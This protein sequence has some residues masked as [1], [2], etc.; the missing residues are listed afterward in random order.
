MSGTTAPGPLSDAFP[1][2]RSWLSD[3]APIETVPPTRADL[4]AAMFGLDDFARNTVLLAAFCA[5]EPEGAQL[6]A[7]LQGGGGRGAATVAL[8]L[9]RVPGAHWSAFAAQAP[10]RAWALIPAASGDSLTSGPLDLPES[11]LFY[12]LGAA[13]LSEELAL[14]SRRLEPPADLSPARRRLAD[15]IAALIGSGRGEILQLCGADPLGK[16]QAAA[17]GALAAGKGLYALNALMLPP[18]TSDIA[19]LAQMWRRDLRLLESALLVDAAGVAETRP[20]GL[21]AEMLRTPFLVAAPDAVPLG[22]LQSLRLDMPRATAAEQVPIWERQLGPLAKKLNGSV[23]RLAGHFNVSPEL[24]GS[25]AAELERAVSEAKGPSGM[26]KEPAAEDLG[27]IAWEACR[28]FARP[29]MDDL[30]RRVEGRAEWKDLILPEAQLRTL[31]AM[32]AQVRHRA[33]VYESWGFGARSMGRGL[34]ISALFAGPSG[35]GKTLAGEVLGAELELDVY[36]IDLSAIVSK[37][38][39]E[40]EK[41]LRRVFDAAEEGCAILQFD[42][43]DALFGKRS[44][45]KDSHDRHANIEVSYLLQRLEEYRGLSILT[46][47]LKNNIDPA[48]LRR[49]RFIVDFGFPEP[50]ER[51]AIWRGIF[52]KETPL[53]D[54]DFERLGQLNL[55]GGSIRN[56]AV[57]A[58]FLAAGDGSKRQR[59]EMSHI[60]AAARTEYEKSGRPMT[61]AEL[62]G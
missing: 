62:R 36:R 18:A 56:V 42:E 25:V 33:T 17:A 44:E 28:Q 61:G 14:S 8:A 53:G 38:I 39:G 46:T 15:R 41:N 29:R 4:L 10:L 51:V 13:A 1:A 9:A 47:N 30:A 2:V 54:L 24:A 59:V 7:G 12:L 21:F 16:E 11:V 58:A 45:V 57:A 40:T 23:G 31:R 55:A 26:G 27:K 43:A 50:A 20:V 5:L 60:L 34:G 6:I 35:A 3:E 22:N 48:F 52:P 32:A 49:I 19:R 37:W